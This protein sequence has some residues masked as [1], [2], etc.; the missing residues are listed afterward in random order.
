M[1]NDALK[2]LNELLGQV[3]VHEGT[4]G[5][6]YLIDVLGLRE[7]SLDDLVDDLLSVRV[8]LTEDGSPELFAL[9]LD[10]VASLHSV[11][12]VLV[13]D[14]NELVIT[15]TPGSL[16]SS[17]SKVWVALFTVFTD[18]LAIIELILDQEF[19]GVFAS[20][21]DVN[22]SKCIMESWLL[23]SFLISRFE[24]GGQ[25]AKFVSLFEIID[26]LRNRANSD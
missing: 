14:L 3:G 18:N 20:R 15:S 6:G 16:V 9:T 5:E 19:L 11:E 13:G 2:K 23:N 7:S 8:V 26:K 10:E 4:H 22:L 12:V 25:H 24:P 17:E 21:I 1:E